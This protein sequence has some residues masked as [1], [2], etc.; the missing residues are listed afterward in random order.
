VINRARSERSEKKRECS[1]RPL[2][3]IVDDDKSVR[4][5]LRSLFRSMGFQTELFAGA[6]DFLNSPHISETSC[7]ILDVLMPGMD[8]LELQVQLAAR[9]SI[10]IIFITG[11]ADP[12]TCV[13]ALR[14]GAVSFLAKPFSE[15]VLLSA[16]RSALANGGGMAEGF[17]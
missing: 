17:L 2:I 15:E 11:Q 9:R 8:G 12:N 6:E 5:A 3:A 13:R 10:P 14:A 7:L 16:L 1:V 4:E